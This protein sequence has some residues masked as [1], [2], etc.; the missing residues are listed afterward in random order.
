MSRPSIQ[1]VYWGDDSW[2]HDHHFSW[3]DDNHFKG[4]TWRFGK[5]EH[6]QS[7]KLMNK[8]NEKVSTKPDLYEP[9]G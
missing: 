8:I 6:H 2:F 5:P 1:G 9:V 7:L 3:F 4:Q